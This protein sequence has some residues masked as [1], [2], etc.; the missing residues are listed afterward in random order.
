MPIDTPFAVEAPD[1]DFQKVKRC[2]LE[3]SL[4][5]GMTNAF[6]R[7]VMS[8]SLSRSFVNTLFFTCTN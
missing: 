1:V 2:K 7:F 3:S 8:A 5:I 4:K 6:Y